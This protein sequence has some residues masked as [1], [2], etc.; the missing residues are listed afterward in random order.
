MAP[1]PRLSAPLLYSGY[2]FLPPVTDPATAA[3]AFTSSSAASLPG[4]TSTMS[5]DPRASSAAAAAAAVIGHT[6]FM[7]RSSPSSISL[8]GPS[9]PS[10][11]TT[12]SGQTITPHTPSMLTMNHTGA[13]NLTN[14]P[15]PALTSGP[16]SI[17]SASS[18]PPSAIVRPQHTSTFTLTPNSVSDASPT[19]HLSTSNMKSSSLSSSSPLSSTCSLSDTLTNFSAPTTLTTATSSPLG[20][21]VNLHAHQRPTQPPSSHHCRHNSLQSHQT[22]REETSSSPLSDYRQHSPNK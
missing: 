11:A 19:L 4:M 16:I 22:E 8:L 20:H 6:G 13:G 21:L 3:H 1:Q 14:G 9:N 7:S 17:T 15:H 2:M 18:S 10:L 5:L 12:P